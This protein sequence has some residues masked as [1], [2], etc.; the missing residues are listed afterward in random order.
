MSEAVISR[1]RRRTTGT[2]PA[3]DATWRL[4]DAVLLRVAGQPVEST[5][6][7]RFPRTAAWAAR[8]LEQEAL[9]ETEAAGLRDALTDAVAALADDDPRRAAVIN[10]RRD[11]FNGRRPRPATLERA[12]PALTTVLAS[13]VRLWVAA[14]AELAELSGAG[15]AV[16]A[17]ERT[18][19]LGAEREVLSDPALRAAVLLQSESLEQHMDRFLDASRKPSK[20]SRHAERTLVEILYRSALKTSPFSTLTSVGLVELGD[21]TGL[22]PVP[23]T[24][25]QQTRSSL[26]VAVLARIAAVVASRPELRRS[27]DVVLAPGATISEEQVRYARRRTSVSADPDAVVAI[28]SVHESL[29][30]LPSGPA[31]RDVAVVLADTSAIT[32]GALSERLLVEPGEERTPEQV[33]VLVGHLVRLGLLLVPQLQVDLRVADPAGAFASGLRGS[34]DPVLVDVADLLDDVRALVRAYDETEPRR[35]HAVLRD[36]RS[37]L[38]RVFA[39]LD[40]SPD[41]LPRTLVYEDAVV[42]E[43]RTVVDRDAW[44]R[45]HLPALA[46]LAEVLPAFDLNLSRRLTARGF[47]VA[48]Y[49][50][51]GTCE[52]VEQFCHEFQ[53]DFYDPYDKR[54][55][56][57]VAF[58]EDNSFVPQENWFKISEI[59]AVD[60]ARAEASRHLDELFRAHD[61]DG[62]LDL[63]DGL[64]ERL[65][66]H[67]EGV[68]R[69]PWA[70]FV[71]ASTP[72]PDAPG[73]LVL[74]QAYTGMTLMFSRFAHAFE[75]QHAGAVDLLRRSLARLAPD[76][77]VLAELRGGYDTTNLNLHPGVTDLEMVCPGEVSQR[78]RAEQVHLSE[79]VLRHDVDRDELR[80]WCPRLERHVLPVYLGFLMPMALPEIQQVLLCLAPSAMAQIDLWAGTG[81]PVP[82]DRVSEYPRLT[83]G[84]LVLHRR[85]WKV[86]VAVFPQRTTEDDEATWYLRVQRWRRAQGIP[87][88]V[89]A[90]VDFATSASSAPDDGD[91]GEDDLGQP[92]A[93]RKPL[94]VDFDSVLSVQL[95]SQLVRS[96]GSRVVFKEAHPDQDHLWLTDQQ[97]R[98]HVTELLVELYPEEDHR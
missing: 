82:D 69:S 64:G 60:T 97:G 45:E 54:M 23:D 18:H 39:R 30:Y 2:G 89:F 65:A 12:E 93:S 32:A 52:D 86:P 91:E 24:L 31:V 13:R 84:D 16:L 26:N 46:R 34:Q 40:A 9:Q 27:L 5:H 90:Q 11:V 55:M 6:P 44:E 56:R 76:D 53:R 70:F 37:E 28:D 1:A 14:R 15:A 10:L 61:G 96:A 75:A 20:S 67:L 73:Q 94:A 68:P 41:L 80:L 38:E 51:G 88:R 25:V 74:N 8:V 42:G 83:L 48:R 85:M 7:L 87:D 47:F 79:L 29:F 35:R 22:L 92:K 78:A 77:T 50:T 98:R 57:R 21:G 71:Q 4:G 66:P 3:G 62:P 33:D 72:D 43:R 49:G 59:E 63:G 81:E 36:L 58:D 95:L 19:V 17:E